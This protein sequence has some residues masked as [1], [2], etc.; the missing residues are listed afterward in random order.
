LTTKAYLGST[1]E[2]RT[3][4]PWSLSALK[5]VLTST[6]PEDDL[7]AVRI[8]LQKTRFCSDD[9]ILQILMSAFGCH[10]ACNI[11][12]LSRGIGVQN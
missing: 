10:S 7:S 5:R 4:I 1:Q 8:A 2:V 12:P 3:P 11:D 9:E 6:L